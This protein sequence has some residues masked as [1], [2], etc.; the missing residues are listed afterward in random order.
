[1]AVAVALL[2]A[3][4]PALHLQPRL[5][6]STRPHVHLKACAAA[7]SNSD[8]GDPATTAATQ[9]AP[10]PIRLANASTKWLV[11]F[12][13]TAAVWT[14]RDLVS[15]FIVIGS[16]VAAFGTALL[17]RLIGQQR[18]AGS[19]F[20]DPGM[21]SSHALVGTF[22]A[23]AWA[24][25]LQKLEATACLLSAALSISVLRV[26]V[27][28]HTWAQVLAGGLLGG[29]SACAWMTLGSRVAPLIPRQAALAAVY[30]IYLLGS[31][32]FI[33][34]KMAKWKSTY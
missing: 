22:A 1:M 8:D 17:K 9:T 15:P 33:G 7:T 29:V 4:G 2:L 10:K 26:A 23:V 24:V 3:A 31:A 5:A 34:R 14:R 12:A 25:H 18:P 27:G 16:I 28:Y 32:L 20:S 30:S 21:P 11:V 6:L 19:P 13:Q